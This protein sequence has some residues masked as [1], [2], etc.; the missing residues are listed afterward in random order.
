MSSK[1]LLDPEIFFLNLLHA[2]K[3][4]GELFRE[5]EVM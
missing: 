1:L 4:E 3:L 5:G 2:L